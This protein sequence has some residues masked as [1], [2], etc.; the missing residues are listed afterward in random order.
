M[1]S[2]RSLIKMAGKSMPIS[3]RNIAIFPNHQ[4]HHHFFV[5]FQKPRLFHAFP[6][7]PFIRSR[8]CS[9]RCSSN[10]DDLTCVHTTLC[11]ILYP[12]TTISPLSCQSFRNVKLGRANLQTST[13]QTLVSSSH[14]IQGLGSRSC[15]PQTLKG[16]ASQLQKATPTDFFPNRPTYPNV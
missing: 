4:C 5:E 6:R 3:H 2:N 11:N 15:S 13:H 12:K 16:I 1:L 7:S 9:D 8:Q 14:T 10:P